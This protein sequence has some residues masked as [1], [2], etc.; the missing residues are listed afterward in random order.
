METMQTEV[1]DEVL[2]L[3]QC[4]Q[5]LK[6]RDLKSD[7]I[8][9]DYPIIRVQLPKDA[10]IRVNA[11]L[12]KLKERNA[13]VK[14]DELLSSYLNGI[15]DQYLNSKIE[16]KTPIEFYFE[17]AKNIPELREKII[18]S[19]K[20]LLVLSSQNQ[21]GDRAGKSLPEKTSRKRKQKVQEIGEVVIHDS[22]HA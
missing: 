9:F 21:W 5:D 12:Q 3:A 7:K 20:K 4:G 16:E 1:K 14:A 13:D 22:H 10:A 6:K 2:H 17:A 18:K 8:G 11:A 15:T 19:A